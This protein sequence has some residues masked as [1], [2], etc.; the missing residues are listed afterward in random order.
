[1]QEVPEGQP[2][3]QDSLRSRVAVTSF[4]CNEKRRESRRLTCLAPGFSGLFT[5]RQNGSCVRPSSRNSHRWGKPVHF[6][7]VTCLLL[8]ENRGHFSST[9]SSASAAVYIFLYIIA[10]EASLHPSGGGVKSNIASTT[11][12]TGRRSQKNRHVF[13][14]N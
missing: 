1:M 9:V 4:E 7:I 2:T 3:T 6:A 10:S 14:P 8:G 13:G 11:T 5:Q 12:T